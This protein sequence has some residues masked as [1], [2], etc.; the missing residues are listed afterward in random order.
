M[1][2]DPY[3]AYPRAACAIVRRGD[4]YATIRS[5]KHRGLLQLPGGK[6]EPGETFARAAKRETREEVGLRVV[7]AVPLFEKVNEGYLCRTFLAHATGELASSREGEA[8]W[9]PSTQLALL[10][11]FPDHFVVWAP[12]VATTDCT[13]CGVPHVLEHERAVCLWCTRRQ[14]HRVPRFVDGKGAW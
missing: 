1:P 9:T 6:C 12:R 13:T 7:R 10:T 3:A 11:A 14:W 5:V 2:S 8:V 4:R